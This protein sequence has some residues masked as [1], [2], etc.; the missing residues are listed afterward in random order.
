[1]GSYTELANYDV[2]KERKYSFALGD[3]G[4]FIVT[5]PSS[6]ATISLLE[7]NEGLRFGTLLRK[8]KYDMLTLTFFSE[9]YIACPFVGS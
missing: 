1:M 8:L 6:T 5:S 9:G 2:F 3:Y 7:N 4:V